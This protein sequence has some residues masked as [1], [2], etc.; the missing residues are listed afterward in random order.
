MLSTTLFCSSCISTSF[1]SPPSNLETQTNH[2][3]YIEHRD[4]CHPLPH[5]T[6]QLHTFRS[7]R[8]QDLAFR[9]ESC[10]ACQ[11]AGR[12]DRLR[13]WWNADFVLCSYVECRREDWQRNCQR[14]L[15]RGV[16]R[17]LRSSNILG[18]PAP[19]RWL[20]S[21]NLGAQGWLYPFVRRL[22]N[23]KWEQP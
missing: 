4:H 12:Q 15:G 5:N 7:R 6:H 9:R 21:K 2:K 13:T 14:T 20:R 10:G 16:F 23:R 8:F 17:I 18:L 1:I 22:W 19:I 11:S 3:P